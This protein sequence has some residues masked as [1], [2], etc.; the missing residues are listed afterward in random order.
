MDKT[1]D[2]YIGKQ[3]S[4]Q[5]EIC[6]ELRKIILGAL[7]GVKEEM[8]MGVPWYGGKCYIV[9]LKDHV[10]IGF[11]LEGLSKEE[12]SLLEGNGKMMRHIKVFS[13]GEIDRKKISRLLEA[14]R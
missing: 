12:T 5:K 8:K 3:E 9:S 4:P 14:L 13:Q 1:V 11:C 6:L 10:N 7:P 2:S